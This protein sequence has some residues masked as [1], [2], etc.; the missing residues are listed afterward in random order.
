[1]LK[2]ILLLVVLVII[3]LLAGFVLLRPASADL[4]LLSEL[5]R[6]SDVKVEG[7]VTRLNYQQRLTELENNCREQFV[8]IQ[9]QAEVLINKHGK[10]DISYWQ[11]FELSAENLVNK[12][13]PEG[14]VELAV[15]IDA[16]IEL[17]KEI[18]AVEEKLAE[19]YVRCGEN[20]NFSKCLCGGILEP[21]EYAKDMSRVSMIKQTLSPAYSYASVKDARN[22][23]NQYGSFILI[24]SLEYKSAKEMKA[25]LDAVKA[26]SGE[27]QFVGVDAEGGIVQRFAWNKLESLRELKT[28]DETE[29]C[30]AIKQQA[31]IL[32]SVGFN[33]SLAP[34]LDITADES[35][36]IFPRTIDEDPDTAS[37]IATIYKNC[38]E[39]KLIATTG[40]H[41]PGHGATKLDSHKIIPEVNKTKVQL[42][43]YD[44]KTFSKLIEEGIPMIM[45]GHLDYPKIEAS[46]TASLSNYWMQ[47]VLRQELG[48][49]GL[50]VTDDISMLRPESNA[51]C[52]LNISL[53]IQNGA[54]L[55]L[56]VHSNT[57]NSERLPQLL[58]KD[59]D[60]SEEILQESVERIYEYKQRY[61]CQ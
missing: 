18:V 45:M 14:A 53:A 29:L 35:S 44:L 12:T 31:E 28:A 51:E 10:L 40:K 5:E 16:Y 37:K 41:F 11:E 42:A 15:E 52:A 47:E 43:E 20:K 55:V 60:L 32:N 59:K 34:I 2:R 48:F 58:E 33:W 30:Q 22:Y 39:A 25:D 61:L 3:F 13:V 21:G 26:N 19:E 17:G 24:D 27:P 8:G 57:C 36:W 6:C 50:I 56:F 49:T 46:D 38:M 9:Q 1:M 4:E 7:I 54:N 23:Q